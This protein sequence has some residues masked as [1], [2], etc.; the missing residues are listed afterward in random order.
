MD[1]ME[2]KSPKL[3]GLE[4]ADVMALNSDYLKA[5]GWFQ[6]AWSAVEVNTDFAIC[7][8]L[9]VMYEQAHMITS[10]MTFGPKA[11]LLT[12]LL[13]NSDHPKREMIASAFKKVTTDNLRNVFARARL[14]RHR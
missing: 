13:K 7:A 4:S 6:T 9:K 14:H 10:G 8:L 1:N 2:R 11:Q 3:E 5:M 12:A